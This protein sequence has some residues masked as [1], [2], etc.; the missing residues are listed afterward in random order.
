[1]LRFALSIGLVA[2][3][4]AL[5][6]SAEDKKAK[7]EPAPKK[8][9][10]VPKPTA[11]DIA[12]AK[13]AQLLVS[14]FHLADYGREKKAPEALIAAARVI[15]T[16]PAVKGKESGDAGKA[17]EDKSL[18]QEADKLLKEA[19]ELVA[20]SR[21]KE[22]FEALVKVTRREIAEG[23]RTPVGGARNYPAKFYTANEQKSAVIDLMGGYTTVT[24]RRNDGGA[25]RVRVIGELTGLEYANQSGWGTVSVGFSHF[26]IAKV[27]VIVINE[28]GNG[29]I[30]T[31]VH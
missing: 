9:K 3:L 8:E 2:G 30:Q 17:E 13:Q 23:S 27:K 6:A 31:S 16:M 24:A 21:E 18:Q 11:E 7:T 10:D 28:G 29:S 19:T 14:A 5:W 20:N 4:T 1:M 26:P 25:I 12:R 15:G 22:H